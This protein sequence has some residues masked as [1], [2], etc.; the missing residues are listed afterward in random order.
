[1]LEFSL[2]EVVNSSFESD[3]HTHCLRNLIVTTSFIFSSQYTINEVRYMDKFM[4]WVII[5]AVSLL[6]AIGN[7]LFK[8]GTDKLGQIPPQRFLDIYFIIQYLFTPAIFAALVFLF[9]GRFLIGSPLSFLGV[10]QAFVAIT[11]LSL[12]S[13][14]IFEAL[15]FKHTYDLW[16]YVGI[17]SGLTSIALIARGTAPS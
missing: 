1:M 16:T 3:S 9:L 10:T 8:I 6:G 13:T 7:I 2:Y 5:V 4:V 12:I 11:V 17:L 15:V 14:L